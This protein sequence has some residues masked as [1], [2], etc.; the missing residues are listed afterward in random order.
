MPQNVV[1]ALF[2]RNSFKSYTPKKV[3]VDLLRLYVLYVLLAMV[4]M[5]GLKDKLILFPYQDVSWKPIVK[6]MEKNLPHAILIVYGDSNTYVLDNQIKTVRTTGSIGH[7]K[8]I[9]SINRSAWWLHT[10]P[11]NTMVASAAGQ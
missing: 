4:I 2:F 8:P 1:K 9:F 3:I 11:Q 10:S 5:T 7:Y 6:D